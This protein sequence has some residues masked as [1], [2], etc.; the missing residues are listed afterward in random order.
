MKR[1]YL[2]PF[3]SLGG[4]G[5][6][7]LVLCMLALVNSSFAQDSTHSSGWIVIPVTEYGTLRARAFPV[8]REAEPLPLVEAT[9]TRVDYELHIYD[10]LASGRANLT[11]DVLKDGW[12]R[13][14][15][16]T[17]LLVR[18]A[19]LE[20]KLVSLVP[21]MGGR[22]GSQLTALLGKRGRAV[23]ALDVALPVDSAAGVEKLSLP[24]SA[25]GITQAS[26]TLT[27]QDMDI[28]VSGGFLSE[29]AESGP[30]V[31]G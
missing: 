6:E 21:G 20:G 2:S 11:V 1:L 16:P 10:Q 9:L 19:R 17:G 31:S 5:A 25:S 18:E 27:R 13:V 29:K 3:S 14:S 7:L 26:V 4:P 12:V 15:I 28:R 30:K 23:L 8:A 22:G 24:A